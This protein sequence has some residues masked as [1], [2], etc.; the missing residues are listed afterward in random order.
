[1][2]FKEVFFTNPTRKYKNG[3][4]SRQRKTGTRIKFVNEIYKQGFIEKANWMHKIDSVYGS[5]G[6]RAGIQGKFTGLICK[7]GGRKEVDFCR[8]EVL[9]IFNQTRF[10]NFPRFFAIFIEAFHRVF[11]KLNSVTFPSISLIKKIQKKTHFWW[12]V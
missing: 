11:Y 5:T 3:R 7:H 10:F 9:W 8:L 2:L 6:G 1:M 12:K 4:K